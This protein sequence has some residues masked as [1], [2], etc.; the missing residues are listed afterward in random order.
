LQKQ[1]QIYDRD[2]QFVQRWAGD[3]VLQPLDS[4][5]AADWPI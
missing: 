1:A 2:N 3:Q 5:D 4:V